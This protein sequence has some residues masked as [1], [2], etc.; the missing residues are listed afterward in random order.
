MIVDG[1]KNVIGNF[2]ESDANYL[3]VSENNLGF[4][5]GGHRAFVSSESRCSL[6]NF[7]EWRCSYSLSLEKNIKLM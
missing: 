2:T 3:R 4:K 1:S 6:K 7:S 5:F